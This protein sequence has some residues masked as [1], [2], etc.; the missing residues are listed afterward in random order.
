[1]LH[2]VWFWVA[3]VEGLILLGIVG[4]FIYAIKGLPDP[5]PRLTGYVRGTEGSFELTAQIGHQTGVVHIVF[6]KSVTQFNVTPPDARHMAKIFQGA[7]DCA[8]GHAKDRDEP[9]EVVR[10]TAWDRIRG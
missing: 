6:D 2:D 10:P 3:A 8:E 9:K 4:L 7:A 1:M 5:P